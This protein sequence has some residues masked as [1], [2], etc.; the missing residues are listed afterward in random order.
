MEIDRSI[1]LYIRQQWEREEEEK[2]RSFLAQYD[3]K[4]HIKIG[5][6]HV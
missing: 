6:A 3:P 1:A 4:N 5:R 2:N